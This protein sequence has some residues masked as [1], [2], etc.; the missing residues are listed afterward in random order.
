M[1]NQAMSIDDGFIHRADLQDI[2]MLQLKNHLA[3]LY[4]VIVKNVLHDYKS[5][6]KMHENDLA[7][8]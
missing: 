8:R 1:S 2:L 3:I 7:A 4:R 6:E 5:E